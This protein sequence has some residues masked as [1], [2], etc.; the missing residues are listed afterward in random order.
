MLLTD[1]WVSGEEGKGVLGNPFPVGHNEII[2]QVLE[3]LKSRKIIREG[4]TDL[5]TVSLFEGVKVGR[6]TVAA[7][8]SARGVSLKLYMNS[9]VGD[10][11]KGKNIPSLKSS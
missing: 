6:Q 10:C 4:G 7:S 9:I 5:E 2:Y 8:R 1:I 11:G 3:T